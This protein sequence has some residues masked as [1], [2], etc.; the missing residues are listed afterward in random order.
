MLFDEI[1]QCN[2][3]VEGIGTESLEECV[4]IVGN[5][6]RG[7]WPVARVQEF[8]IDVCCKSMTRR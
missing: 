4:F 1:L 5:V 6:T 2:P 8:I 3:L 7:E